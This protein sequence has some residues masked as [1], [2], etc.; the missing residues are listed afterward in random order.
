MFTLTVMLAA[1][2][3]FME[4][5]VAQSHPKVRPWLIEHKNAALM[6]SVVLGLLLSTMFGAGGLIVMT[7]CMMAIVCM[8]PYYR[9]YAWRAKRGK[10]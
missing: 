3:M 4:H 8:R 5:K 2:I 7:A 10:K 1:G 9:F 6:L